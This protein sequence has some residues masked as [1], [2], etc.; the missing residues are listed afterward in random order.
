MA[1]VPN[2]ICLGILRRGNGPASGT[3]HFSPTPM[4]TSPQTFSRLI[5]ELSSGNAAA[6]SRVEPGLWHLGVM[7]HP[8]RDMQTRL[9]RTSDTPYWMN[10]VIAPPLRATIHLN[11]CGVVNR[12]SSPMTSSHG[13]DI[14]ASTCEAGWSGPYASYAEARSAAVQVQQT[15]GLIRDCFQCFHASRRYRFLRTFPP[16]SVSSQTSAG[17]LFQWINQ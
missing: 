2:I 14:E 15:G 17:L 8:A 7:V 3:V 9:G 16:S 5:I 4:R 1:V 11:F 13:T 6:V 12:G 10:V